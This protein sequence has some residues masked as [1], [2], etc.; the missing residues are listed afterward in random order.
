MLQNPQSLCI[1][2]ALNRLK[3]PAC[4]RLIYEISQIKQI[5][6]SQKQRHGQTLC[7]EF[8]ITC[9]C[10]SLHVN[11]RREQYIACK[12]EMAYKT[13]YVRRKHGQTTLLSVKH[14]KMSGLKSSTTLV[15]GVYGLSPIGSF[16]HVFF[17][18]LESYIESDNVESG[19][20]ECAYKP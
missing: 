9:N 1:L 15:S 12:L 5:R 20:L 7:R 16:D 18:R 6:K 8:L 2:Q 13:Q 10:M 17:E 3:L 11:Y 4:G 14:I 19:D